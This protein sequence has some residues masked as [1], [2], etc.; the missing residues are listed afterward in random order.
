SWGERYFHINDPDS[1][2]LSFAKP[3]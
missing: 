2:E 1:H 3:L